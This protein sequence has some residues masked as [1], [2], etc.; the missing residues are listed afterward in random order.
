MARFE[1]QQLALVVAVEEPGRMDS[2]FELI[3]RPG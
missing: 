2:F 1:A 3:R